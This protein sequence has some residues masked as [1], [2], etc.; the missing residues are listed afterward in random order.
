[1]RRPK[2]AM[3]FHMCQ[4][5]FSLFVCGVQSSGDLQACYGE[6]G[7]VSAAGDGSAHELDDEQGGP[8][9]G[10]DDVDDQER[11]RAEASAHVLDHAEDVEEQRDDKADHEDGDDAAKV[12][13]W[14]RGRQAREYLRLCRVD[15]GCGKI[16]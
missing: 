11:E 8:E 15:G 14:K 12:N 4:F 1:M 16:V 7:D 5:A 13:D 6:E 2:Y 10:L 3:L 9:G